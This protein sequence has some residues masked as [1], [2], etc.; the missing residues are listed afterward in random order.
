MEI[1][2]E[3]KKCLEIL[4]Q[5]NNFVLTM[6]THPDGDA[7]GSA[8]GLAWFLQKELGKNVCIYNENSLPHRFSFLPLPCA[9]YTDLTAV[10]FNNPLIVLLDGSE[11][12]RFGD[13][14]APYFQGKKSLCIDHH[15]VD[16][17]IATE[18]SWIDH[19]MAA[20][21]QMVAHIVYAYADKTFEDAA[22]ALYVAL[23]GDTGNF[24]FGNTSAETVEILAKLVE[25]PLA[26][27]P[28]R[29][30]LDNTWTK[31]KMYF[32]G[33]LTSMVKFALNDQLAYIAV[34]HALFA[35]Y[36]VTHEDLE[37][38]VERMRRVATVRM[39]LMMREE[40]KNGSSFIKVSMRSSGED[41]VRS[42]L[43]LFGGGGHK[44][45]AGAGSEGTLEKVFA[46]IYPHIEKVLQK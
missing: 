36:G 21:G 32:W 28:V 37:G 31:E 4:K 34:P 39:T 6:H 46:M 41:D 20:T 40:I 42:L 33:K 2:S 12:H 27:A 13:A 43:S 5:N 26:L 3:A 29:E 38:F 23:S 25:T 14:F 44:N 45:A 35:E 16:K 30:K 18:Y 7:I 24:S 1:R 9:Y 8:L 11:V 10:P 17:E 15:L 22:A 19:T